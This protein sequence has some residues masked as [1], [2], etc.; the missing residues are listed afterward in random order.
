VVTIAGPHLAMYT[1]PQS[2]AQAIVRF[3]AEGATISAPDEE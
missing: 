2:A 1:N 3:I